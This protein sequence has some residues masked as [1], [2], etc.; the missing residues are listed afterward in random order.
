MGD[1]E[2]FQ[3]QQRLRT[4]PEYR[5]IRHFQSLELSLCIFDQNYIELRLLILRITDG[6]V[7]MHVG[8]QSNRLLLDA[9]L[10]E[11]GRLLHNFIAAAKSLVDHTRRLYKKHYTNI[12]IPEYQ[13]K[14]RNRF[15]EDPQ[16]Q[17]VQSLRS[18]VLHYQVPG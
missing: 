2:A 8:Q 4:L 16:I 5:A 12:S 18:Y 1:L 15:A 13:E 14:L 11:L 17:F 3:L 6:A 10:R 7:G 9:T